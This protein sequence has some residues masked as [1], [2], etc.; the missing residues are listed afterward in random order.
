[1]IKKKGLKTV[2]F[3]EKVM[4]QKIKQPEK[5]IGWNIR[6]IRKERGIGQTQLVQ[7]LQLLGV[8]ITREALVKIEG[9]RQH[10]TRAQICGVKF[11]LN[12]TYEELL[13]GK[14]IISERTDT[15]PIPSDET[16]MMEEKYE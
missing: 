16:N 7:M 5:D 14:V 12:T 13:E 8:N 9:G 10:I 15:G 6:R 3:T 1:M 2:H 4:G 11:C